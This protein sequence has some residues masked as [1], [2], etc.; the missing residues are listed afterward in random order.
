MKDKYISVF[1]SDELHV[2]SHLITNAGTISLHDIADAVRT[3]AETSG[4]PII[5]SIYTE[6]LNNLNGLCSEEWSGIV[7]LVL[8]SAP[9]DSDDVAVVA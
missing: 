3:T 1:N 4:D 2:L 8:Y 9:Y 7:P 6:L 5:H